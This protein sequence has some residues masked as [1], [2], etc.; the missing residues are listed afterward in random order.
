MP[1]QSSSARRRQK[2]FSALQVALMFTLYE[3]AGV[4]TNL[5][6]GLAGAKWGIK[7]TL[8]AGA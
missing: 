6:A 1:R 2:G 4:V 5:G 7:C 3:L 8:V